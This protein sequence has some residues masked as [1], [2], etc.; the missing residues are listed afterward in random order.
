MT[1]IML[2]QISIKDNSTKDSSSSCCSSRPKKFTYINR[3][4]ILVSILRIKTALLNRMRMSNNNLSLLPDPA[5]KCSRVD[6]V[7]CERTRIFKS[8]NGFIVTLKPFSCVS[9]MLF[10]RVS[11]ALIRV[12]HKSSLS[13]SLNST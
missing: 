1:I 13:R 3:K 9:L 12:K 5:N 7:I 6:Q 4:P 11:N 10:A 2:S 8:L